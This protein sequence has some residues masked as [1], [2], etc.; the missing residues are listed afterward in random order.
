[1]LRCTESAGVYEIRF[2]FL[3][4]DGQP[5]ESEYIAPCGPHTR[6][7]RYD[8]GEI[9]LG[10]EAPKDPDGGPDPRWKLVEDPPF[11]SNKAPFV[12]EICEHERAF[13]SALPGKLYNGHWRY[14]LTKKEG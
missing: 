14:D 3:D 13:M 8:R 12:G 10:E 2:T 11:V 9:H 4:S 1:M 6:M 5:V 7:F